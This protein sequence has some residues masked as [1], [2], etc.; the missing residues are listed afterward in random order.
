VLGQRFLVRDV[1]IDS[2]DTGAKS[3]KDFCFNPVVG[4]DIEDEIIPAKTN[5]SL[6]KEG[7]LL[8]ALFDYPRIRD[9]PVRIVKAGA[10]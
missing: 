5:Q 9:S 3:Y 4:A 10:L 1:G 6:S 7:K 8:F 2:D